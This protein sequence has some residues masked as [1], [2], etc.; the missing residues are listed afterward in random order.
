[1]AF[2]LKQQQYSIPYVRRRSSGPTDLYQTG[3]WLVEVICVLRRVH[4]T[5]RPLRGMKPFRMFIRLLLSY[6]NYLY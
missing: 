6:G 1:M 3:P 4:Q 5:C 2:L